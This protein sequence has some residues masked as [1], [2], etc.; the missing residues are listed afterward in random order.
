L[1]SAPLLLMINFADNAS[2]VD[3]PS[4]RA[5]DVWTRG[6]KRVSSNSVPA[7][8]KLNIDSVLLQGIGVALDYF[9]DIEPDFK[10]GICYDIRGHFL[11][12]GQ[13][14][15]ADNEWGA[16]AALLWRQSRAMN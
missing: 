5:S 7:A 11:K 3:N 1:K 2:M 10:T 13:T 4:V 9:G 12:A 14:T 6:G 16:I 8:T 15:P